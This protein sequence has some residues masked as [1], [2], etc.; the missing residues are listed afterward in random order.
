[1]SGMNFDIDIVQRQEGKTVQ[2]TEDMNWNHFSDLLSKADSTILSSFLWVSPVQHKARLPLDYK[3]I[4]A[5]GLRV[6]R[7][8]IF[9]PSAFP[10]HSGD[11]RAGLSVAGMKDRRKASSRK[12]T[13]LCPCHSSFEEKRRGKK[14]MKFINGMTALGKEAWKQR[15]ILGIS[16]AGCA[17]VH[18]SGQTHQQQDLAQSSISVQQLFSL[19]EWSHSRAD[20]LGE[21]ALFAFFGFNVLRINQ[22][23]EPFPLWKWSNLFPV[24][25]RSM[26]SAWSST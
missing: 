13:G 10:T 25:S 15:E 2:L 20:E 17:F 7:H 12:T 21:L 22:Y 19:L 23:K 18:L 4:G 16:R 8:C 3:L 1:M 26:L 14:F 24:S 9:L 11:I 6:S 5:E